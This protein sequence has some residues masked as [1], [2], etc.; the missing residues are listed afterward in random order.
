[1]YN[2]LVR[3]GVVRGGRNGSVNGEAEVQCRKGFVHILDQETTSYFFTNFSKGVK[4][5][6]LWSKFA[7]FGR[8]GKVYVHSEKT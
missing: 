5:I 7:R 6:D 1:M 3:E 4:A 2:C 8:V